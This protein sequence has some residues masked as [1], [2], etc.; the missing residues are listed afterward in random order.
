MELGL[1]ITCLVVSA[2]FAVRVAGVADAAAGVKYL[3]S[4]THG[5]GSGLGCRQGDEGFE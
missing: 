2:T 5:V 1:R 4:D 3:M